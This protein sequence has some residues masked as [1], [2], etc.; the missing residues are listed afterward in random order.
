VTGQHRVAFATLM[1][2]RMVKLLGQ[3]A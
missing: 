3:H 1:L 2:G